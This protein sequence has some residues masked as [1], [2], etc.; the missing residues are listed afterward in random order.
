[1]VFFSTAVRAGDVS[2]NIYFLL[3]DSVTY[4]AVV[5]RTTVVADKLLTV[6]GGVELLLRVVCCHVDVRLVDTTSKYIGG[7]WSRDKGNLVE[8]EVTL[9]DLFVQHVDSV[10][11]SIHGLSFHSSQSDQTGT[12]DNLAEVF[13]LPVA[14]LVLFVEE[15]LVDIER[16]LHIRRVVTQNL[17]DSLYIVRYPLVKII[18][19]SG[20]FFSSTVEEEVWSTMGV[21]QTFFHPSET[22]QL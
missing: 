5:D 9:A 12:G 7:F 18:C 20:T 13:G 4:S 8:R 6:D 1:M 3:T 15:G 2:G 16:E 21:V 10:E 11:L 14:G 17:F 22:A 19:L